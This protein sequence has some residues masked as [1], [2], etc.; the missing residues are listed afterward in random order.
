MRQRNSGHYT[1]DSVWL[2]W[3]VGLGLLKISNLSKL[4][5]SISII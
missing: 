1:V 3:D 4:N 2:Y 5:V